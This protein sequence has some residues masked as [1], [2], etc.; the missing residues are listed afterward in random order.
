MWDALEGAQ[1]SQA[2][3]GH[4]AGCERAAADEPVRE[5]LAVDQLHDDPGAAVLFDDIVHDD[6]VRVPDPRDGP[7][8]A[9][10]PLPLGRGVGAART[11]HA[12]PLAGLLVHVQD[13][14]GDLTGQ[15]F[16]GGAP[17]RAHAAA[18]EPFAQA[19]AAGDEPALAPEAPHGV[20]LPHLPWSGAGAASGGRCT[21]GT[22]GGGTRLRRAPVGRG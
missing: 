11:G 2:D 10:R 12:A 14:H 18:A 15:Q 7:G 3:T 5:G 22:G 16:V 21:R 4:F 9:H 6:H 13:L 19:I 8:L 1:Q 17:D 20:I